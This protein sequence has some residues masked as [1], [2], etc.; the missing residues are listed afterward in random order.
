MNAKVYDLL[1]VGGGIN[2][3]AIARDAAGRGLSVVLCEQNDLASGTSWTST[4]LI[5]G[6]LRYLE[7]YEFRLVREALKEREVLMRNAPH[8][9]HPLRLVLPHQPYLRP[10]WLIKLGLWLYD[11]LSQRVTL[12]PSKV[13]EFD[14]HPF[15]KPL[16]KHLNTGFEFSDCVVDDARLVIANALDAQAH[17][18]RIL[19]Y[20]PVNRIKADNGL[21]QVD[22]Y[23]KTRRQVETLQA[24]IVINA[25]GPWINSFLSDQAALKTKHHSRL[26]KGSH[27]VTEKRFEGEQAYVIQNDDKRIVFVI[28]FEGDYQLIGTTEVDFELAPEE[29]SLDNHELDYLLDIYNR[30]FTTPLVP[31]DIIWSYSGVRPLLSDN[32]KNAQSVTRDYAIEETEIDGALC[33]SIF[34]GKI[35]TSRKLAE[36]VLNKIRPHFPHC[37]PAWTSNTPIAGGEMPHADMQAF[38]ASLTK[39]YS[40]MPESLLTRYAKAYGTHIH[41]VIGG[42]TSLEDLGRHFGND[43]YEAE[44]RH[45][46]QKEWARTADDILYRRSKLALQLSE[47]EIQNVKLWLH[48]QGL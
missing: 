27:I 2:G 14:E 34:G 16:Q 35:T 41:L 23:D 10:T 46:V 3:A 7:N 5:H 19:S 18:A 45:L 26:V 40:W 47:D 31:E 15:G 48:Q 33:L 29:A 12:K 11:H 20:T 32:H 24:H 42:A 30:N 38:I 22:V 28:P 37:A 36:E 39:Q 9:I 21:W 4:K 8:L 17:G 25:T 44:L 13:I 1:V 43:C 6:G